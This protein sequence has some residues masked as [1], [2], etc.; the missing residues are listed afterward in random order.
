[1][2]R[3]EKFVNALHALQTIIVQARFLAEMGGDIKIIAALL[4]AA[5]FLPRLIANS[6]DE[7]ASF[8]EQLV[9]ISER[10][11]FGLALEKFDKTQ[12]SK[13]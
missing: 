1:M 6:V 11:T 5:E 13:W 7:T 3:Q 8:R 2:I 12:V 4:D 10:F 9:D